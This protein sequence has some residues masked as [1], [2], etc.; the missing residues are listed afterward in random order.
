M[1]CWTFKS[2]QLPVND[3]LDGLI[4]PPFPLELRDPRVYKQVDEE[5]EEKLCNQGKYLG[6]KRKKGGILR[7]D[8][9][10]GAVKHEAF[11]Q[12]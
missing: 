7:N 2:Y 8:E 4:I 9:N 6:R 3:V 10:P 11:H 5:R 12:K 1:I